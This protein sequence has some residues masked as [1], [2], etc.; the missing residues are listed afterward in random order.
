LRSPGVDKVTL[1]HSL[2]RSIQLMETFA[3]TWLEFAQSI[4]QRFFTDT[5]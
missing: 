5:R 1:D 2:L 4:A 3:Q